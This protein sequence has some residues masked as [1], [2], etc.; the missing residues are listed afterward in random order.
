[1]IRVTSTFARAGRLSQGYDVDQ[2]DAFFSRA[3]MAYE[4]P[5]GRAPVTSKDVRTAGFDLVRGGYE[6][7]Q[8]DSALD[9]L[10]DAFA[11]R[12]HEALTDR[13]GAQGAL[14]EVTRR[15]RGL[16][17]R[18]A[19]PDGDRFDRGNGLAPSYSTADVDS[20]CARLLHY[21]DNGEEM[22][23]DDVRRA[24]FRTRRGSRGYAEAQVDAFLDRVVEVMV[25]AT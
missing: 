18:L 1:M 9:R 7:T 13:L 10:E 23:V 20:L 16:H 11:V 2:V 19:R 6:V 14:D 12:E 25:A 15:A 4:Q 17:G 3:R 5:D 21:F 24:V 8:V 22:S